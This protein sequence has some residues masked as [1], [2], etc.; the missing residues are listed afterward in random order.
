MQIAALLTVPIWAS[1]GY[2][3]QGGSG[4]LGYKAAVVLHKEKYLNKDFTDSG[5][6]GN[7]S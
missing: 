2:L 7:R 6:P 4:V 1:P 5:L 3:H